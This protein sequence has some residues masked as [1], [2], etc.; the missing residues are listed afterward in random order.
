V[1]GLATPATVC[2]PG[3]HRVATAPTGFVYPGGL[4]RARSHDG[5]PVGPARG[6]AD[7]SPGPL[8]SLNS[9]WRPARGFHDGPEPTGSTRRPKIRL[10][11]DHTC[12]D[13]REVQCH[14][15]PRA[16][17]PSRLRR[18]A[19]RSLDSCSRRGVLQLCDEGHLRRHERDDFV[20]PLTFFLTEESRYV[21]SQLPGP[22]AYT[23]TVPLRRWGFVESRSSSSPSEEEAIAHRRTAVTREALDAEPLQEDLEPL[24]NRSWPIDRIIWPPL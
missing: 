14:G 15:A 21:V 3:A 6:H 1:G 17:R 19:A 2:D 16:S 13:Q 11:S 18:C 22:I 10:Q 20:E 12:R 4:H 5:T 8:W 24:P 9:D 7:N 23:A